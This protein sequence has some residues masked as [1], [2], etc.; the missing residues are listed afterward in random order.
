MEKS[1]II[2]AK[3][4]KNRQL[5]PSKNTIDAI[6]NYSKSIDVISTQI[7]TIIVVKN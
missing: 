7:G 1:F 3:T 4:I 2:L 5:Q 6:L